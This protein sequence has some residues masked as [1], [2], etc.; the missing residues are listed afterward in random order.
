MLRPGFLG[1]LSDWVAHFIDIHPP[2]LEAAMESFD[3]QSKL[4]QEEDA[5][6]L[7]A[8]FSEWLVF[9]HASG[10][11]GG[12]TGLTYFCSRNPLGLPE[13]ETTAYKALLDFK[14]G[15]FEVMS[16]R[17]AQSVE[18]RDME[19]TL[20]DVVDI[21]SSMDLTAGETIW[22]RIA[23]ING[24]YHMV[25]SQ[26]L[27]PPFT[28]SPGM[29]KVIQGWGK[30]A[31]DAKSVAALVYDKAPAETKDEYGGREHMPEADA[32]KKFDDAL[33]GAGM[34]E[35][36][37]G[38]TVKKW[39]N[40]ERKFAIGFP[41]K[42]VFFLLP[43]QLEEKRRDAVLSTL[44]T[45]LIN[46]PR[47]ALKGKTPLQASA[48]QQPKERH[49]D[50]D[51]YSY[52]D[53]AADVRGAN[54]LMPKDPKQAY[55]AYERLI[56]RLLDE[57]VPMVTAFRIF[58]NA[59]V[60]LLQSSEGTDPLGIELIHAALRLNPLYDFGIRQKEQHIDWLYDM[61]NVPR[62]ERKIAQD[63]LAW[64]E[65]EGARRY[66]RTAFRKY[67]KF[68]EEAGISLKYKTVTTSTAW[69]T[70]EDGEV[71]KIGRNEP[72][73]CGSGKKFKRCC[74]K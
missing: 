41:M 55:A 16:V 15:Y 62:G 47:R 22:T 45:Y 67:E 7:G 70:G 13:K 25:G 51:M 30:N 44:Q 6:K 14:V 12:M 5:E 2:D 21:N 63:L 40:N 28:Y 27:R 3:L 42:T 49:L 34:Q 46:L 72:C 65:A 71:I 56:K 39:T 32:A 66:R 33:H 48:E 35:M 37:S 20:Y 54:E 74:G 4:K 29:K 23:Q 36:I 19:G 43:E 18:L 57:K 69:R 26:V 24:I 73:Y 38:A 9:D 1:L 17:P 60:C 59:G 58:C 11:F 61:S 8:L 50:I 10:A 64:A 53:Y 31:V 52:E 68:L